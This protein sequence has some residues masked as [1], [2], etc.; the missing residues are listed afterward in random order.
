MSM[1]SHLFLP[2]VF[3]PLSFFMSFIWVS[4]FIG[5]F[6]GIVAVSSTSKSKK[7]KFDNDDQDIYIEIDEN[8]HAHISTVPKGIPHRGMKVSRE[9]L[10]EMTK[11]GELKVTREEWEA[12]TE[13][14][15]QKK[16]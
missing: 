15:H 9:R 11:S 8:D 4:L 16:D 13:G 12:A 14:I 2:S 7:P 6:I 1:L 3:L 5:I 10:L